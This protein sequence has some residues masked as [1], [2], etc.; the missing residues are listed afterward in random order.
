[1]LV[2]IKEDSLM[3]GGLCGKLHGRPSHCCS[4]FSDHRSDSQIFVENRDLSFLPTPPAFDAPVRGSPSEYYHG[5][6]YGET[7]WYGYRW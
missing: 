4:H 6:W 7:N 1:M 3:R 2:V 5:V